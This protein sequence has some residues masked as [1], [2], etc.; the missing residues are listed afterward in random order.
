VLLRGQSIKPN[1]AAFATNL[2]AIFA[3]GG[4]KDSAV[5]KA[6]REGLGWSYRQEA[7]LRNSTEGLEPVVELVTARS[8]ADIDRSALVRPALEK[9]VAAWTEAD[10]VHAIAA[11]EALF[12][13]GLGLDPLYFKST[14]PALDDPL[15]MRTYW[16]FKTGELWNPQ[17]L[18]AAMGN[19]DVNAMRAAATA[20]LEGANVE[21]IRGTG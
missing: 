4:G 19:V 21:L 2:L 6:L 17:V 5:W 1:D 16:R 13:R 11:A 3:L 14:R 20:M 7:M 9:A 18:L 10:R 15:F 8:D 12:D